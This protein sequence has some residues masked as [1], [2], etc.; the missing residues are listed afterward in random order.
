MKE[1]VSLPDADVEFL[2]PTPG[3]R[4]WNRGP[5]PSTRLSG[6]CGPASS[7][8]PTKTSGNHGTPP[9]TT[10]LVR[11]VITVVPVTASTERIYPFRVLLPATET[12][13]H[14]DSKAQA[15]QVRS[16][17]VERIGRRVGHPPALLM[18]ELDQALRLHLNL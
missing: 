11:A 14:R 8:P 12:G 3:T 15:E 2:M 17:A 10:H 9:T 16:V 6:C 18:A 5:R 7:P 1:S 13:L 4:A